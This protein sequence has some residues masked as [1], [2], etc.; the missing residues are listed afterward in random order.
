MNNTWHKKPEVPA[1][2]T[3]ELHVW[4]AALSDGIPINEEILAADERVRLRRFHFE[5]DRKMFLLARGLLRWLIGGY[6]DITPKEVEFSYTE[7]GKP[8]LTATE[9]KTDLEFNLSHSGEIVL[10]AVTRSTPVGVDVEQIRPISDMDQIAARFFSASERQ[11]LDSLSGSERVDAFYRCWTRKESVIKAYG[12]GLSMPL[13]SFR[14]SLLP[15]EPARLLRSLDRR[16]WWLL[17]LQPE[18]GYAAAVAAS[19]AKQ[20]VHYFSALG[21]LSGN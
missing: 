21:N 4:K 18:Q 1:I 5:R 8:F 10:V 7:Y 3:D 14:V 2:K 16:H 11:D 9:G 12:E 13:D 15:G 17:D 20:E 19:A 6:V